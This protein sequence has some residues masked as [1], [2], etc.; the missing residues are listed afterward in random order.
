MASTA[1]NLKF[2]EDMELSN[3]KGIMSK[4][5]SA[6]SSNDLRIKPHRATSV[7]YQ[8]QLDYPKRLG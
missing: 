8:T 1:A 5:D 2:E 4:S 3:S 6:E 7:I